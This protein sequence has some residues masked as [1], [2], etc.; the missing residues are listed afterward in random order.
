MPLRPLLLALGIC[1]VAV[2]ASGCRKTVKQTELRLDN[3]LRIALFATPYGHTASVVVLNDVGEDHD[4]PGRSGMTRLIARL[5]SEGRAEVRTS[6]GADY[7]MRAVEVPIGRLPDE[8]DVAA[9]LMSRDTVTEKEFAPARAGLLTEIAARDERDGRAA[10]M[11]RAAEALAPSRGGGMRGGIAKEVEAITRE[12]AEAFRRTSFGAATT[13]LLVAGPVDATETAKRLRDRFATVLTGRAPA[14]R[15]EGGARVTGTLVMGDAP[16][17]VALAVPVPPAKDPLY[18]AFLVLAERV[19][20]RGDGKRWWQGDFE[21]LARPDVLFVT[22]PLPAGEPPEAAAA[23]LR[24]EVNAAVAAPL[25]SDEIGRAR[26]RFGARLGMTTT[27][28]RWVAAPAEMLFAA[29]RRAQLGIDGAA[30]AQATEKIT[31]TEVTAAAQLFDA[32][33]SAAVIAGGKL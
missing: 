27:T 6:V 32:K 3:G 23:R 29:G 20:G 22:A 2:A 21:P 1:L 18:P 15:P 24:A 9:R 25:A 28:E 8:I 19:V 12:E 4:P 14:V 13:R 7:T 30:L 11:T 10:A 31:S 5:L 33:R 16:S 17:A 26:E